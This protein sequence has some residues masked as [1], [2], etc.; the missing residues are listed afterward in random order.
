MLSADIIELSIAQIGVRPGLQKRSKPWA[1]QTVEG[2][3]REGFDGSKW[4]PLPVLV[5]ADDFYEIGGDGH[6]RLE[7]LRRLSAD[8][9]LPAGFTVSC[10]IVDEQQAERLA[11]SANNCRAG[12]SAMEE[13]RIFAERIK[14]GDA[15]ERIA[16]ENHRTT[17]YVTRHLELCFLSP[18]IQE[19]VGK[20][21]Y[22]LSVEQGCIFCGYC[23]EY[24]L[25]AAA[26][27]QIWLSLLKDGDFT[28]RTLTIALEAIA[29][30]AK[31]SSSQGLLFELPA[32]LRAVISD[33]N[34][35]V[36]V[37]EKAARVLRQ[38][39]ALLDPKAGGWQPETQ[40]LAWSLRQLVPKE[41]A[42]LDARL[43]RRAEELG[44]SEAVQRIKA[45]NGNNGLGQGTDDGSSAVATTEAA[46]A[47]A[48]IDPVDLAIRDLGDQIVYRLDGKHLILF[49]T[50][51]RVCR[52]VQRTDRPWVRRKWLDGFVATCKEVY[53]EFTPA[54]VFVKPDGRSYCVDVAV[55]EKLAKVISQRWQ[56]IGTN[57]RSLGG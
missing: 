3:V 5:A 45:R 7:A 37:L 22:G 52:V 32:N 6:S 35:E 16:A 34:N 9:R 36:K 25:D 42:A 55:Y 47:Q 43:L 53:P 38:A 54:L 1:E 30:K 23:R 13:A 56:T 4:D 40:A 27:Q 11:R 31:E 39:L 33:L 41:L 18:Q 46:P 51:R 15:I 26:Q 44:L 48:D 19:L 21:A 17:N 10:R 12:F 50:P 2:I 24:E 20:M 8:G 57:W 28:G 49:T 14:A 29:P